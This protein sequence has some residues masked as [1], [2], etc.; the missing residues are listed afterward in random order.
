[1]SSISLQT[2]LEAIPGYFLTGLRGRGGYAEVW[3][4][5]TAD[6]RKV[7]LKFLSGLEESSSPRE[8]RAIQAVRQLPHP[9][10]VQIEQVLCSR[11]HIIIHME[12]ADASLS[13]LLDTSLTEFG[14]P[15]QPEY[16]CQLLSQ[17]ADALDFLNKRHHL[18][19]GKRVA[20][21]HCDVK[22]SNLLLFGDTVKLTD[23][24]LSTLTTASLQPHRRAGT[25]DYAAPEVFQGRISD[26]TDQYALAITFCQLRSGKLPFHD[27]PRTFNPQY[28]RPSPDL[29][30]LP[31]SERPILARALAHVPQER[32]PT[33]R[34][35]LTEL[36]RL[37]PSP[38][39]T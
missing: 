8:I 15:I 23:F 31:P 38:T 6:G 11:S 30:I 37:H 5:E 3:E 32:W 20:I 29:T 22:P 2:G 14:E 33:C 21:Q 4:A 26:H 9:H 24:G 16:V 27:T 28:Q 10:L 7:A 1:M 19:D 34:E 35:F 39:P 13:E 18:I 12:L 36:S 25:L 17:A